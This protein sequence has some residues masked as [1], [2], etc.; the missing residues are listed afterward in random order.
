MKVFAGTSGFSYDAWHGSF[1]PE[2]LPEDGRLAHYASRLP[3]VEINNSFYKMPSTKVLESWAAE[4][5]ASFRFVLKASRRITH[6]ARLKEEAA[7]PLGYLLRN[8]AV[9]G[10]RL[11]PFLFQL[12]PNLKKDV[13][14]LAAFLKL[15]PADARAAFEFRHVSWF[16]DETYAAL[17]DGGAA[18]CV[19][20]DEEL[21][22]PFV[23]TAGWGYL[24]LRRQDYVE[25]DLAAKAAAM[26]E[27]A[28]D[29][30]YVFFKHE[31]AG[32]GPVLAARYLE[33]AAQG[34]APSSGGT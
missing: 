24:R 12:P 18:L 26:R 23:A 20:E 19:A 21:A 7:E 34:A 3:A 29:E 28:W 5:P 2:D 13:P 16:D 9:L 6:F 8:A 17:R 25:S 33:L 1:Y 27:Q 14:R 31:D 30:A 11:G 4:T 10:E 32:A 15:L 22:T